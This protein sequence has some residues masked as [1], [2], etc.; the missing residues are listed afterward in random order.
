MNP[1]VSICIP[2][3]KRISYLERLLDSIAIQ[4]QKDFE[5]IVTDDTPGDEVRDLCG[6]YRNKFSLY[7]FKN[8]FQLGTPENWN[9]SIRHANGEWIKLMHDDD[10]FADENTLSVFAD[11][12]KENPSISFFYSAYTN[13]FDEG[14]QATV[15]ISSFRKRM[16]EQNPVT[17]FSKN[18]IGPP[19]VTLVRNEKKIWYDNKTKWIVDIDFYMRYLKTELPFY[20]D[21]PLI[22]VGI[23]ETQ[24]TKSV[25]RVREV[26]IPENLYLLSKVGAQ[27]LKNILVYD[28]V[29]RLIR[30]LKVT[31]L[32][33]ISESGYRGDVPVIVKSM[34]AW[35]S[36]IPVQIL[37]VG[38]FSKI[39]MFLHYLTHR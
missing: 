5:V 16:L 26:E 39:I 33:Q 8:S 32:A 3:Y 14:R 9:E 37:R 7:Y 35:Q 30:N 17:L 27:N 10:W 25:F 11:A 18:V 24:V 36:K 38:V 13:V 4:R 6:L 12:V 29:W 34:I 28:A 20:I 1:F 23:H 15:Y 21:K 2:A 22:N 31:S 19:S